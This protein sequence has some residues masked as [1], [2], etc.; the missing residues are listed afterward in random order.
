MSNLVREPLNP[1]SYNTCSLIRKADVGMNYLGGLFQGLSVANGIYEAR[2]AFSPN[3]SLKRTLQQLFSALITIPLAIT[4][5]HRTMHDAYMTG[6]DPKH[7]AK[8]EG[9]S[10][11]D[12]QQMILA[13]H[14]QR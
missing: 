3:V 5:L 11:Y 13:Y 2:T 7:I 1:Y 6:C 10:L 9:T 14:S 12:A 8:I 4:G